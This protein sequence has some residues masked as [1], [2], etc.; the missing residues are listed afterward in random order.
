[1][2]IVKKCANL[3]KK[4]GQNLKLE[5]KPD[6]KLQPH[7][8]PQFPDVTMQRKSEVSGHVCLNT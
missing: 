5:T 4:R 7:I 3:N 1:M 8:R 2:T 6:R